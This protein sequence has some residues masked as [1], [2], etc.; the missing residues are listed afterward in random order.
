M[1]TN[2][3]FF[4]KNFVGQHSSD[5]NNGEYTADPRC[6]KSMSCR[7]QIYVSGR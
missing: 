4:M 3:L 6:G 2:R 7:L 5:Q 1:K